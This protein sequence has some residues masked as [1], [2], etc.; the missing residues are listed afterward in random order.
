MRSASIVREADAEWVSGIPVALILTSDVKIAANWSESDRSMVSSSTHFGPW[1]VH[2]T[3]FEE[4]AVAGEAILSIPN[5]QAIACVYR[6][7]PAVPPRHDPDV[8]TAVPPG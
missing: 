8:E 2:A 6:D 4:S 3:Q 5:M 1:A 7:L